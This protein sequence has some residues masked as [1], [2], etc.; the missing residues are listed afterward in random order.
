MALD[1]TGFGNVVS[2]V[3][4]LFGDGGMFGRG[5]DPYGKIRSAELAKYDAAAERGLHPLA[6]A[7]S[8][9]GY[10]PAPATAAQTAIDAGQ[11]IAS[12][13]DRKRQNALI[14]A[15]IEE[16]RSRTVLNQANTRRALLGPQPGIGQGAGPGQRILNMLEAM[17][18]APSGGE[19]GVR[20]EPEPDMP[21]RQRVWF[22][23]QD[24]VGPNP[25]AFEVGVS[26]LVAGLMIYGP[27]WLA[28]VIR[29]LPK[30]EVN[31]RPSREE[32]RRG[33]S[34]RNRRAQESGYL[35]PRR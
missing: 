10:T 26:E 19:R 32:A 13:G 35:F 11:A 20:V 30:P 12:L 27:Q 6:V 34:S 3:G 23:D 21:A 22:G 24:A 7:G 25:E 8:P 2:G 5:G 9:S 15:Q 29:D 18:S 31:E 1:L 14:D 4:G 17:D 28:G 16:A 33:A